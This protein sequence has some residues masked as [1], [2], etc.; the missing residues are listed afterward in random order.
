M[1]CLGSTLSCE[2]CDVTLNSNN[3]GLTTV[4][5]IMILQSICLPMSLLY[6]LVSEQQDQMCEDTA[7][8]SQLWGLTCRLLGTL[9]FGYHARKARGAHWSFKGFRGS[10]GSHTGL[11]GLKGRMNDT[12]DGNTT[13]KARR[14][15]FQNATPSTIHNTSS[16][17]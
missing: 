5:P 11:R 9:D 10:Q 2:L 16:R 1:L 17:S 4:N 7:R 12:K 6:S 15:P 14:L 3:L 13:Y 8:G